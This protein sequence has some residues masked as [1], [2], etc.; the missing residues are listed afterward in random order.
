MGYQSTSEALWSM[1]RHMLLFFAGALY[2]LSGLNAWWIIMV[3]SRVSGWFLS[4]NAI[5]LVFAICVGNQFVSE[6]FEDKEAD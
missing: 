2:A 3:Q 4:I 5:A 1:Y 6:L